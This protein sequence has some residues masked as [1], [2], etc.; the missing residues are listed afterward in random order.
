[1]SAMK[2]SMLLCF[3]LLLSLTPAYASGTNRTNGWGG[4]DGNDLLPMCQ[5]G[6]ELQDGKNLSSSR[7]VDAS[8][9]L[10]YLQGFL[11]GFWARD[12]A[13]GATEVLCFPDGVN[14]GQMV[15][16]V[17]KW[18]Q[19]HPAR[20]HEPAWSCIFAAVHDAFACQPGQ[21]TEKH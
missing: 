6:L 2:Q 21:P 19:D 7:M 16:V 14:A 3:G 1:M 5:A 10:F 13:P 8:H 12:N 18:M 11:D 4:M 17:T 15:R 9:C 20:L